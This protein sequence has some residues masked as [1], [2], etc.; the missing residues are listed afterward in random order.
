MK[1]GEPVTEQP[2]QADAPS[3]PAG[4]ATPAAPEEDRPATYREVFAARE[5]RFVFSASL[6]SWLGDFLARVALA[7][8]VYSR[9]RSVLASAATLAISYV[10]W[11]V[12]GPVLSALAERYPYRRVMIV[13]DAGRMVLFGVLAIPGVPVPVLL[14]VLF[15]ASM[16]APPFESAR[17]ALLPQLLSGDRYVVGLSVHNLARQI[18]QVC[19]Y[20]LGGLL[21]VLDPRLALSVDAATFGLSALLLW[22]FVRP[23]PAALSS[24][25]RSHLLRETAEGFQVVFGTPVLRAIAVL[26]FGSVVFSIVPEGL[27]AGWSG[28]L[29]GDSFTQGLIM[30]A[31]PV[32]V[33]V[34]GIVVGRTIAPST[35]QRIIRPLAVLGPLSLVP[36]LLSPPLPL[37]I[38]M[39]TVCGFA[40]SLVLPANG[41]FVQAL[42]NGYRA[43]A[44]GVM[45]GG[46]QVLQG[47][48]M[49][50][51]GAVAG[52]LGVARTVG[53][54]GLLGLVVMVALS[55]LWPDRDALDGAIQQAKTAN[56]ADAIRTGQGVT[57][58]S[59][60]VA[61]SST[62]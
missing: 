62:A 58:Q 43:R 37:V 35:R 2:G 29:N 9:T 5:F 56:E 10:P 42:P 57:G 34:G 24:A 36:S 17:S 41:L 14:V 25:R 27:A 46:L 18:T 23:R 39:V 48:S 1:S 7:A 60:G 45:Q 47:L 52:T 4:D 26:V 30:A 38:L 6:L 31:F 40:M 33:V 3:A 44:F 11:I 21:S 22:V 8:L 20:A 15:V 12:G 50:V 49:V 53:A 51:A 19:G 28:E 54:T 16:M 13:C 61:R 55:V 32:G 59:A